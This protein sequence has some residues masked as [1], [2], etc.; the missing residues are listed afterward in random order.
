MSRSTRKVVGVVVI[1]IV[2]VLAWFIASVLIGSTKKEELKK[3][4]IKR[5]AKN[6]DSDLVSFGDDIKP[7]RTL[8]EEALS[9]RIKAFSDSYD[10][11]VSDTGIADLNWKSSGIITTNSMG[12]YRFITDYYGGVIGF[13]SSSGLS[14]GSLEKVRKSFSVISLGKEGVL[15]LGAITNG[16]VGKGNKPL[17]KIEDLRKTDVSNSTDLELE[18]VGDLWKSLQEKVNS[19]N[20]E[21]V[22]FVNSPSGG[23]LAEYRVDS[24]TYV[25]FSLYTTVEDN[26]TVV[27]GRFAGIKQA[28]YSSKVTDLFVSNV[29]QFG[30]FEVQGGGVLWV[31]Y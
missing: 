10:L 25:Y 14:S 4:T 29:A 21:F 1:L 11:G 6:Q 30:I 31:T 20:K 12:R 8:D 2:S 26:K 9:L 24:T 3:T 27:R 16:V 13:I 28:K 18:K 19:S 5:V 7:I 22:R 17:T 23:T 15:Y